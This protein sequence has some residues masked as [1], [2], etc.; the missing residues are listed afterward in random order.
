[1]GLN[2]LEWL[3]LQLLLNKKTTAQLFYLT[4]KKNDKEEIQQKQ[5][6]SIYQ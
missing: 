5:D 2:S 1:M 4:I 3:L 6:V